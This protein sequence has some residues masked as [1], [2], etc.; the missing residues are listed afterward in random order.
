[1]VTIP[2]ENGLP[3]K[4]IKDKKEKWAPEQQGPFTQNLPFPHL[5]SSPKASRAIPRLQHVAEGRQFTDTS[6]LL[7]L[8]LGVASLLLLAVLP[9]LA[10]EHAAWVVGPR[11]PTGLL[12]P[13]VLLLE[14]LLG[15]QRP[16]LESDEMCGITTGGQVKLGFPLGSEGL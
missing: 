11:P 13:A 5:K 10:P 16:T 15:V 12:Q 3:W 6:V 4:S 1:M 2:G 7:S 9:Q 14:R 8:L